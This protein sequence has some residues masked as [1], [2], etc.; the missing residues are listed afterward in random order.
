M[1]QPALEVGAVDDPLEAEAEQT[2]DQVMGVLAARSVSKLARVGAEAEAPRQGSP[3]TRMEDEELL[4]GARIA[5][6]GEEDELQM[7]RIARVEEEEPLQGSRIARV[8][9]EEPLQG[10][11]LAR[12]AIGPEGGAVDPNL[13]AR[14]TAGSGAPL[15]DG[16]RGSMEQAFGADFSAVRVSENAAAADIGARAYTTGAD[17]RFAPGQFAPDSAAGQHLLAHEL[18]HV[19][20]QGAARQLA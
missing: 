8:E 16:V 7:S 1:L 4:Q 20:Q 13:E 2:A 19:V 12:A 10:S 18:T 17:I 15:P 3:L 6:A 9:E 11:R 14:L 5:R